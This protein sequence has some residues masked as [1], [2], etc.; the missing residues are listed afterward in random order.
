[1]VF[2]NFQH[3]KEVW[4]LNLNSFIVNVVGE[5]KE[6]RSSGSWADPQAT[7]SRMWPTLFD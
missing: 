4:V 1:M 5:L 3:P 2:A 7:P 6:I